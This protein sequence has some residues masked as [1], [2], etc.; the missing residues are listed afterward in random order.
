MKNLFLGLLFL[1]PTLSYSSDFCSRDRLDIKS[2][3]LESQTRIAFRNSGGLFNKGVCWWHNRLQRSAVYLARFRPELPRPSTKEVRRIL[4]FLKIMD[5]VVI[6]PGY[7]DFE[8]FSRD[9]QKSIQSL[10]N[11]WQKFDGF[12]N[13][14]WRRGI[15]GSSSL[16]PSEMKKRM[17]HVYKFYRTSP[18][19]LWIMAQIKGITSHSFL[20]L[21][22]E[23]LT[24]GYVM[25]VIDSNH[26]LETIKI[27]YYEGDT[28]LHGPRKKY[29]F[30][31]YVGFQSDFHK[32]K[33]A[34]RNHC[35]E[36]K[37]LSPLPEQIPMGEIEIP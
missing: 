25:S 37:F 34:L 23:K 7:A 29:T 20:V 3:L 9:Y 12:I 8:S 17:D 36:A 32:I 27:D 22:M 13:H 35:N 19:P 18:T 26:P 4:E 28:S 5:R 33:L 15:S 6:I 11:Q 30:V 1:I 31:P 24:H 2:L 16:A 14:E 21:S 10:L